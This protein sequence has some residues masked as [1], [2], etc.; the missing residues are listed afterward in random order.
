MESGGF[1]GRQTK[2]VRVMERKYYAGID[3]GK[4]YHKVSVIDATL[5]LVMVPFR[6]GRGRAGIEKLLGAVGNLG[7]R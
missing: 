4:G 6:I 3:L 2:E 1:P 7:G 5:A